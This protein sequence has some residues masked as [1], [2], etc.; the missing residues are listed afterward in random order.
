MRD[1]RQEFGQGSQ[2]AQS[3]RE[4]ASMRDHHLARISALPK[5]RQCAAIEAMLAQQAR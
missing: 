2:A 5:P 1:V 3:K 4:P